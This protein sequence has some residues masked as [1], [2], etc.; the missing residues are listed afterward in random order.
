[1]RM[2]RRGRSPQSFLSAW[3]EEQVHGEV[4]QKTVDENFKPE[5]FEVAIASTSQ[6]LPIPADKSLLEVLR[7]NEFIMPASCEM[8]VCGSCEC[9]YRAGGRCAARCEQCARMRPEIIELRE[10]SGAPFRTP[11]RTFILLNLLY[12]FQ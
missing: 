10:T 9:G 3:P 12:N 5:P 4:F 7:E 11:S 8:G 1:M 2:P 6:N